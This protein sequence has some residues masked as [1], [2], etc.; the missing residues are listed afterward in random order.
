MRLHTSTQQ[1]HH[2][3]LFC[4][5]ADLQLMLRDSDLPCEAPGQP[6]FSSPVGFFK[7]WPPWL[8]RRRGAAGWPAHAEPA[9]H[10][11]SHRRLNHEPAP[12]KP[13]S[14]NALP[15]RGKQFLGTYPDRL[16]FSALN[17]KRLPVCVRSKRSMNPTSPIRAPL[18]WRRSLAS[19]PP[20]WRPSHGSKSAPIG[21]GH[22]HTGFLHRRIS[23]NHTNVQK[24]Q[25][26]FCHSPTNP[27]PTPKGAME[28]SRERAA[29]GPLVGSIRCSATFW[30]SRNSRFPWG[31]GYNLDRSRMTDTSGYR[32]ARL[33]TC[34]KPHSP[35]T[36]H[37]S[38]TCPGASKDAAK[39][40]TPAPQSLRNWPAFSWL[41]PL[42]MILPNTDVTRAKRFPGLPSSMARSGFLGICKNQTY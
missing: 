10:A 27:R 13:S 30:P 18:R 2:S 24:D 31:P 26:S 41:G 9:N 8:C 6:Y 42:P 1:E 12:E 16:D 39:W 15:Q 25:Q 20:P 19:N 32:W 4:T 21:D 17:V 37:M 14:P 5:V 40:H 11:M 7:Q 28:D 36:W 3:P 34:A 35:G 23:Q 33:C 29:P 38:H 22:P